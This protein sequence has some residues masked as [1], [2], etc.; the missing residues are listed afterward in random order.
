MTLKEILLK[1]RTYIEKGWTQASHA[2]NSEGRHVP[3]THPN[4]VCWCLEGAVVAQ[5]ETGVSLDD[6]I[7]A[8]VAL[9]DQIPME[10]RR[11]GTVGEQVTFFN[12]NGITTQQEALEWLDKAI[13]NC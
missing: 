13:A 10:S 6:F 4:A 2:K 1:A 11:S 8:M 7:L 12:D 9:A 5:R 3:P